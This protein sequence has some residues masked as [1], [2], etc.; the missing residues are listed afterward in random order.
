MSIITLLRAEHPV[1][2]DEKAAGLLLRRLLLAFG[3]A[4]FFFRPGEAPLLLA[5]LTL[6]APN[7]SGVNFDVRLAYAVYALAREHGVPRLT[8]AFRPAPGF[9]AALVLEKS[10][11]GALAGLPGLELVDLSA[12]AAKRR[13]TDTALVR[14]HLDIAAPLLEADILVSLVKFKAAEG[15]LFGSGLHALQAAVTPDPGPDAPERERELVDIYS[16][17]TPD[18]FIVDA[19]K[20]EGGFQPQAQDC[21]VGA[22]DAVALDSVLA[23]M[24]QTALSSVDSLNLAAQYG[25]GVGEPGGIAM[26]GD[27]L[28]E[29]IG[30]N[31]GSV[32]QERKI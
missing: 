5:D 3:G 25:L 20:G 14:D 23:A 12:V 18:L 30:G 29:I 15:R 21:L 27:D 9:A 7:A 13:P 26:Y 16:T 6:P 17:V 32:T 10:G 22:V 8:L 28:G 19:L 4:E 11:Y 31:A 24:S 2:Q 1:R